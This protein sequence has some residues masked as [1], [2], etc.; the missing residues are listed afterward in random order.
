MAGITWKWREAE[1]QRERAVSS[2]IE[3]NE[4]SR[5]AEERRQSAELAGQQAYEKA[6][7][8]QKAR[9]EVEAQKR[10]VE[11]LRDQTERLL[12]CS[13]MML[14]AREWAD[15]GV[16]RARELLTKSP[17]AWRG[18]ESGYLNRI[19][20]RGYRPIGQLEPATSH[21]RKSPDGRWYAYSKGAG[22]L[23]LGELATGKPVR[24]GRFRAGVLTHLD[25]SPDGSQLAMS[26]A[27]AILTFRVPELTLLQEIRPP[28]ANS[29]YVGGVRYHPSAK[30]L[31]AHAHQRGPVIISLETEKEVGVLALPT[32]AF[33][34]AI[35]ISRDGKTIFAGGSNFGLMAWD[36]ETRTPLGPL[37]FPETASVRSLQLSPDGKMLLAGCSDQFVRV[38]DATTR[39]LL[40]IDGGFTGEVKSLSI[41]ADGQAYLT[42]S[43]RLLRLKHVKTG[44]TLRVL[45]GADNEI[46]N[47]VFSHDASHA[48]SV[49]IDGRLMHWDCQVE[50]EFIDLSS[51]RLDGYVVA[52]KTGELALAELGRLRLVDPR[53]AKVLWSIV[54]PDQNPRNGS[55][56]AFSS[57]AEKLYCGS[58]SNGTFVL[59]G[60][61]GEKL[62]RLATNNYLERLRLSA[63][64]R[65][66]LA[67][68]HDALEVWDTSTHQKR[69]RFQPPGH[70]LNDAVFSADGRW[71]I[72]VSRQG[73]IACLDSKTGQLVLEQFSPHRESLE[74]VAVSAD[75]RWL[76][77]RV[78]NHRIDVWKIDSDSLRKHVSFAH[79]GESLVFSPD[80][81]RLVSSSKVGPVQMWMVETGQ[82]VFV[83]GE[84]SHSV[85]NLRF[86]PEGDRLYGSS[87]ERR[88][89]C[90]E[91]EKPPRK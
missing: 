11:L 66:L 53:S 85:A 12:Y 40:R 22:R 89:R 77:V 19:L 48:V 39:R 72:V 55:L 1:Q 8:E 2:S 31:I 59:D 80:S 21:L 62:Y 83:L 43:D 37:E 64:D 23:L 18:W 5:I 79:H 87:R 70:E 20:G 3:A 10:Q 35:E 56:M 78:S 54:L 46:T 9:Q 67:L 30:V 4:Q 25:F 82:D 28:R 69:Y 86:S 45:R 75:G 50:Q 6:L 16:S 57:K 51:N 61:T 36:Y 27:D 90:W 29:I 13:Q 63:D 88:L 33:A 17:S 47:V 14:A 76:A 84:S 91:S 34:D 15:G 24:M 60:K 32:H 26:M 41:S 81:T 74:A 68:Y 42:A 52:P 44:Q 73:R 38:Y 49:S 65:L 58:F 7:A 71:V